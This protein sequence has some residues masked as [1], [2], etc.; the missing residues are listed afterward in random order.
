MEKSEIERKFE[1]FVSYKSYQDWI[2]RYKDLICLLYDEHEYFLFYSPEHFC[3]SVEWE[4]ELANIHLEIYE[5]S[6]NFSIFNKHPVDKI[7]KID[8]V[9]D[10]KQPLDESAIYLINELIKTHFEYTLKLQLNENKTY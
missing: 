10:L 1:H 8:S 2:S 7:L 4:S 6:F 5:N 9:Y 3:I